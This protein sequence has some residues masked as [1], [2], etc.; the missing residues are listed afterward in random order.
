MAHVRAASV[1]DISTTTGTGS[2]TLA[3]TPPTGFRTVDGTLSTSDTAYFVARHRSANEWEVFLG[4]YSGSHVVARTTTIAGSNGASA[5]NFSAG[6][7]DVMLC[8]PAERDLPRLSGLTDNRILRSDGTAGN[9]QQTGI[10]V[11]DSDNVSGMATLTLPN[12]GLHILDTN[13]THDLIIAPGSNLTADRT[14]TITTGD[15]DRTL[16]L[17]ANATLAGDPIEQGLH[18]IWMPATA[19]KT[20]TTNGAAT[21][22]AELTTNK[23]MLN[24]LDFDASTQEFAQFTIRMP[25]SWNEGTVTF[26]PTWSH[27]S[28]TTNFG[29]VWGL[30]AVAISNDDAADVAFGTA[31]TSADTGGTTDDL[32]IG[33]TSSAITIAGSPAAED[34]VMFQV[35]RTVADGSDTMAI[36]ARL[37]GISVYLTLNAAT[38]A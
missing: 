5:V 24:S 22:T 34:L 3:N 14:L 37:I 38:D 17:S 18:T 6:T 32:Y 10:T 25:K 23:N 29:V 15:A 36:D 12:T 27:A 13:A 20:R 21:G 26:A 35:N 11:D 4:T 9:V 30:Q 7:K 19:M 16:T 8:D 28:T 33:P 1:A 31:Q 2:L